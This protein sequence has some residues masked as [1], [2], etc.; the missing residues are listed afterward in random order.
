MDGAIFY[1]FFVFI[2]VCHNMF[3]PNDGK[4]IRRHCSIL[5]L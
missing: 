5:S 3:T 4:R 2:L 1:L